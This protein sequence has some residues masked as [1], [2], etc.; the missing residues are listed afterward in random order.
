[1]SGYAL[2][3][4]GAEWRPSRALTFFVQVNNVV[5]RKYANAAQ[6]GATGFNADGSAFVARPFAGPVIG[7]ERP[8]LWSTFYAPGAPR[9]I[10]CGVKLMFGR[11]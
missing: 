11:R 8:L 2:L 7:G 3:D 9:A 5:D 10:W 4:L 1:M 6:L